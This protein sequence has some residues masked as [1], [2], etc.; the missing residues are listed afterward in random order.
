MRALHR[1]Y[2][3][4]RLAAAENDLAWHKAQLAKLPDHIDIDQAFID[5]CRT[6]LAGLQ[7]PPF[8]NVPYSSARVAFNAV[9][10]AHGLPLVPA[11][12]RKDL[13]A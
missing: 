4:F 3:G 12:P 7:P 2:V 13:Q 10:A 1:W 8:R 5:A 11:N 6:E 9:L